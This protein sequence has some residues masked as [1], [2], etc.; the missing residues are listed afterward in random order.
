MPILDIRDLE[1]SSTVAASTASDPFRDY[2]EAVANG[3]LLELREVIQYGEKRGQSLYAHILSGI[4]L[5]ERLR[6]LAGLSDEEGRILFTGYTLHDL[7]K[8]PDAGGESS[9]ARLATESN[10]EQ[11]LREYG[12]D[13]FFPEYQRF[14]PAITHLI[15]RHPGHYQ[16]GMGGISAREM[17]RLG[18]EP[19][20]VSVLAALVRAADA[21]DLIHALD[22][23]PQKQVELLHNINAACD[24]MQ[25]TLVSHRIDEQRG[26][27]TNVL[28]NAVVAT[29]SDAMGL[30]PLL[31]FPEGV[32][33]L[34]PRGKE[35]GLTDSLRHR[36][37]ERAAQS[38]AT[39][40]GSNFRD[41]I[42][43]RPAGLQVDP[44][45]LDLGISFGSE[46]GLLNEMH[47]LVQRAPFDLDQVADKMGER[48]RRELSRQ[49]APPEIAAE[50][51][52]LVVEPRSMLP[53]TVERLRLG[54]L[55]RS[56]YL[57]LKDHF[58]ERLPEPWPHLYD[59]LEITEE[60]RAFY[61]F[62]GDRYDRAYVVV[63]DLPLSAEELYR[64]IE[65]DGE[66]WMAGRNQDDPNVE[67]LAEYLRRYASFS[68]APLGEEAY[69]ASLGHYVAH[70]HRQC[71]NCAAPFAT[72]P[73]MSADVR[74]DITV[75]AFSN[76]LRGGPG[77]PKKQV[78]G[79][80]RLQFLLEK[81]NYPEVRGEKTMY[82]HLFSYSF[83]TEGFLR[84]LRAAISDIL[85]V[86]P[87]ARALHLNDLYGSLKG[88]ADREPVR[89]SFTSRTK[90]DKYHPYGL[91]LPRFSQAIGNLLIFPI[92]PPGDNDSERALFALQYALILQRHFGMKV[93]L[94]ESPAAPLRKEDFSDLYVDSIPLSLRGLLPVND[95]L[96]RVDERG[97]GTL[98]ELWEVVGRLLRIRA[99]V[100]N[101]GSQRDELLTLV[102]ALARPAL[103]LFYTTEKLME[104]RVR[105]DKRTTSRE[106]ALIR[107]SQA[108]FDDVLAL[109]IQIGGTWMNE[110]DRHLTELAAMAWEHRLRGRSLEKN[111]LMTPLD[112]IF[113]KLGHQSEALKGNEEVLRAATAEDLMEHIVRAQDAKWRP[114]GA[115]Q[116]A[117]VEVCRAFVDRFF[118]DV[119][120]GVYHGKLP[121]LLSDEKAL[122]SAFLFYMRQHIPRKA[123]ATDEEA[124][125][126]EAESTLV[127]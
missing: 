24:T 66:E 122:R 42:S 15:Q 123:N 8:F 22:D 36:M 38:V 46:D 26:I 119:L 61:S 99:T 54:E 16:V 112:E 101:P 100:Y 125:E 113:T 86:E 89:L 55:L 58:T 45:C 73:W 91:Y 9:L 57:F 88:F 71:V 72:T 17:T 53:P 105:D 110:L 28:H 63:R 47:R 121:R 80:C 68:F 106:W 87:D 35:L 124:A 1:L 11:V 34:A 43:R 21:A 51:A 108:V 33:Y 41:F 39:M 127:S 96:F 118:D 75:Q 7:N 29:L 32:A 94:S 67:L 48:V 56:Y 85:A 111:S 12:L 90:A 2:V 114:G 25:Y 30:I 107:A 13:G 102:Q 126:D 92:N 103:S 84:G 69:S 59:L 4:Y 52:G 83:L 120:H 49:S 40:V 10:V 76:R 3:R 93:L 115:K 98:K 14:I 116:G 31:F 6:A 104:Q 70:Q 37:G 19:E 27:L 44:K 95:Y 109:S 50:V 78:C 20:R 5:L 64:R 65:K 77:E 74:S 18:I 97:W 79:I 117:L 60:R 23:K 62:F 82:L 81:L